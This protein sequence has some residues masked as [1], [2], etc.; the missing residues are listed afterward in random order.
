MRDTARDSYPFPISEKGFD[1]AYYLAEGERSRVFIHLQFIRR[2]DFEKSPEELAAAHGCSIAEA[3]IAAKNLNLAMSNVQT[4][5]YVEGS[6]REAIRMIRGGLHPFFSM[7]RSKG[8][9][10]MSGACLV[11]DDVDKLTHFLLL[12]LGRDFKICDFEWQGLSYKA[13]S[14]TTSHVGVAVPRRLH[15]RRRW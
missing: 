4:H 9:K 6:T 7:L 5:V 14:V 10:T 12:A 3:G 15:R 11:T 2:S 8:I 1:N 13:V